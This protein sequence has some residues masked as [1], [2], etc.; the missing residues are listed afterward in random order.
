MNDNSHVMYVDGGGVE[1]NDLHIPTY[2]SYKCFYHDQVVFEMNRFLTSN[3]APGLLPPNCTLKTSEG[4]DSNNIAEYCALYYGLKR[5]VERVGLSFPL[6]VYQDSQVIIRT[7][8]SALGRP[9][10]GVVYQCHTLHLMPWL[11]AIV[12]IARVMDDDLTLQ[13]VPRETIVGVLDH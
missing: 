3:L 12:T 2:F 7:V 8:L 5:Y 6:I 9:E 11:Q 13:W 4:R 1:T 10:N